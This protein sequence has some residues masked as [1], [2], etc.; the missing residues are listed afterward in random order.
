[1]HQPSQAMDWSPKVVGVG[2]DRNVSSEPSRGINNIGQSQK[3][4]WTTSMRSQT[5]LK[6]NSSNGLFGDYTKIYKNAFP[7]PPKMN[8]DYVLLNPSTRRSHR[9]PGGSTRRRSKH[10]HRRQVEEDANKR[11]TNYNCATATTPM[12]RKGPLGPKVFYLTS[13]LINIPSPNHAYA[14]QFY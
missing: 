4:C 10:H 8:V 7:P 11:C 1:M 12:W 9:R 2:G 14:L 3:S 13:Y 5:H 6:L